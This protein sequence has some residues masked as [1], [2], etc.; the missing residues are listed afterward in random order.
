VFEDIPSQFDRDTL[1][2]ALHYKGYRGRE[3]NMLRHADAALP[4]ACSDKVA[5]GLSEE[6]IINTVLSA[7]NGGDIDAAH[8]EFAADKRSKI[9]DE[10]IEGIY[11]ISGEECDGESCGN[12][13]NCP[14]DS[15]C[16]PITPGERHEARKNLKNKLKQAWRTVKRPCR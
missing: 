15:H 1:I 7:L 8:N 9:E 3:Y 11:D 10:C 14:I 13:L 2:D 16:N 5:F 4:N 12:A 6:Y